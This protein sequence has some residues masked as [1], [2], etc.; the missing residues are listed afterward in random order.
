MQMQ[1]KSWHCYQTI[2]ST[3]ASSKLPLPLSPCRHHV[4]AL[5]H[6][7]YFLCAD[8]RLAPSMSTGQ[9]S[10]AINLLSLASATSLGNVCAADVVCG[11]FCVYV[12]LTTTVQGITLC[13]ISWNKPNGV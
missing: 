7:I 8:G 2:S 9:I 5:F 13:S 10:A 4:V 3:S 11:Y 1:T 6:V 12:C